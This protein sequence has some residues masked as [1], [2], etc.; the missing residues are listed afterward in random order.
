MESLAL[1]GIALIALPFVLPIVSLVRSNRTRARVDKLERTVAEL[2]HTI[3]L[4]I[5]Q[6]RLADT[7]AS[8]DRTETA[9]PAPATVVV[10][11]KPA[12]TPPPAAT[13]PP[14]V[15]PRPVAPA[16]VIARPPTPAPAE[17]APPARALEPARASTPPRPPAIKLPS[18]TL[19]AFE[20]ESLIGVK[21][22]SAIAGVALV[23]AAIFF[24]RYSI[25]HG[26]LE[27]PVRVV[28]G[29]VV[30][31]ALLVVCE[32]KAAR[33]YRFTANALDAAAIAILFATFFAAHSLWNLIPAGAA[34]ALLALVTAVAVL[35]SIRRDS[36]F[37]A[38][39][40]LLGGFA[41]PAL[42]STGENRP[43]P[44][45]AYLLLLNIGLAWVAYRKKWPVLSTLTVVLTTVYQWGWVFKFLTASQLSLAAGIFLLFP[46]VTV[47]ALMLSRRVPAHSGASTGEL[48]F[49]RTALVAAGL[50]LLFAV[51]FAAVPAYGQH[52]GLLFGLLF[53]IDV[54]LF[55]IALARREPLLHA[56]GAAGTAAALVL[57]LTKSYDSGPYTVPLAFLPAFVAFFLFA[58]SVAKRFARPLHGEAIYAVYVAPTL[59][60]AFAVFAGTPHAAAAPLPLFAVLFALLALLAWRALKTSGGRLY[61]PAAFFSIAAQAVWSTANMS[62]E[63]FPAAMMIYAG[64][65]T[66]SLAVPIASRRI[67]RRLA[68]DW[69]SG[70]VLL[71]S[72]AVM[73][74]L[75]PA[76]ASPA[77]IWG[78]A[79][80]VVVLDAAL[81]VE[82]ASAR[83]PTVSVAAGGLSLLILAAW[84]T[85]SATAMGLMPSLLAMLLA[86]LAMVAAHAWTTDRQG[87][88]TGGAFLGL[89]GPLFLIYIAQE[90]SWAAPPWPLFATLAAM[91]LA[92]SV[93]ALHSN[94]LSLH[95]AAAA[96]AMLVVL[97]WNAAAPDAPWP[98]IALAAGAAIAAYSLGWI[99]V[100]GRLWTSRAPRAGAGI[101]LF[102]FELVIIHVAWV[103]GAPPVEAITAAHVVTLAVLLALTWRSGWRGVAPAAVIPAAF[104]IV[105]WA[106][107]HTQATAWDDLLMLTTGIYVVFVAYPF[108]LGARARKTRDPHVTAILASVLAFFGA[109]QA[110]R[111]GGLDHLVGAIP[112]IEGAVLALML[113][114]LL[115][116]QERGSRDLGRLALVAGASLAFV[117]VAIPVQLHQQWITIGWALEAAALAW[118][119]RRIP[120][121]GLLLATAGLLAVVF[122]RL[123]LNPEV[124]HY[125]PRGALR[126]FNWYLYTYVT[127]AAAFFLAAWFLSRTDDRIGAR[128][129]R[130]S[131][132]APA[133]GAVL[134]FVV[135][136][137]EIADFYATGPDI[138]FRFGVTLAQDLTYTIGWLAF[139]ILLLV[140]GIYLK[141]HAARIAAL[142]LIAVTT[143]KCFLYDLSSL[144]GL[145]RVGSFVGLALALTLVSLALQKYVLRAPKET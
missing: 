65:G 90:P 143:F 100:A 32:L 18:L 144:G 28:I 59:L 75:T 73:L 111:Q 110:L 113:R 76:T 23:I 127:C 108:V 122:V 132:I 119:Y 128:K 33:Q 44:L 93:A 89:T 40:G 142:I 49:E 64:L 92:I 24:L 31:I 109:R 13:L 85:D 103:R 19:P 129:W 62:P 101:A 39:L 77:S 58:P 61:F 42:L 41:T 15:A 114:Q 68:P 34:F 57:W 5:K 69:G 11:A 79:F 131:Q 124:F 121:R 126:I 12:G 37:I 125:E 137:I 81:F 52:T 112:I 105:G 99:P 38:V 94:I 67:G 98:S 56:V 25:E 53:M 102:L 106:A 54:G 117:T 140:A 3:E 82:S 71:S 115:Q 7:A 88:L 86:T 14:P 104:A 96:G 51:H 95:A 145:H 21:L 20:W 2:Q 123:V 36:L 16:P 66:L 136:N 83:L 130:I 6:M 29:I 91:T 46:L 107:Q 4:L 133:G 50:P 8:A 118:L 60:V 48:M 116:I 70:A 43:I 134:L 120:H 97:F 45:F 135:L 87:E 84:W 138:M 80:L 55:A 27:P 1:I 35:L 30:S 78:F 22:F 17:A 139:G 47:A 9:Q 72:L 141:S 26:W 63:R 10:P 74:F